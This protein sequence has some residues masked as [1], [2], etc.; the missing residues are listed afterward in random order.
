MKK[1]NMQKEILFKQDSNGVLADVMLPCEA[2]DFEVKGA[3]VYVLVGCEESQAVTI[4]LRK[5]GIKAYSCDLLPC[6]GGHP[7]WHIQGD[8]F[9]AIYADGKEGLLMTQ[10]GKPL[11]ITKWDML[12]GFPTCTYLTNAGIG[13]FNEEKW[14]EKAVE[15]K[16]KRLEAAKF[17]MALYNCHIRKVALENPVGWMNSSFRKPDQIL[18]PY[19]FGEPQ[20]KNIC[21]WLK[22][23]PK[24]THE[25]NIPKPQPLTVQYRKP[26][27]YYKG[28]EE[29][30]RYFTDH[31]LRDSV[32][33]S[34]TFQGIAKAMA[35][36]W[37][38]WLLAAAPLTS[39]SNGA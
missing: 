1:N 37:G 28:G 39:K 6:S 22:N 12:I 25:N 36:Q 16:K 8:I 29:K 7:E 3:A 30:K 24:I 11:L 17:F 35:E 34:K 31:L 20:Q 33:R 19:Y 32:S 10:D 4:E 15:R 21:L 2:F 38:G 5:L 23:V 18:R 27:K 9:T 14:G 26:S 13:Y